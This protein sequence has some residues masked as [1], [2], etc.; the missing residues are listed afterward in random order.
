AFITTKK[1]AVTARDTRFHNW[2]RCRAADETR[3]SK[4]FEKR[5]QKSGVAVL[6]PQLFREALKPAKTHRHDK[7]RP[8]RAFMVIRSRRWR[9]AA[10]S[11]AAVRKR[12][13]V[14]DHELEHHVRGGRAN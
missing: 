2:N 4:R 13:S 12:R 3:R 14:R 10:G 5:R 9:R 7:C 11:N 1:A 6:R 8:P